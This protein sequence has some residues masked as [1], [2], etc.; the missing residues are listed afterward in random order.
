MPPQLDGLVR[1]CL[2]R[3]PQ[4]R[5]QSAAELRDLLQA[6]T[7]TGPEPSRY[8]TRWHEPLVRAPDPPPAAIEP[9]W[10]KPSASGPSRRRAAFAGFPARP[11]CGR[12]RVPAVGG[13]PGFLRA[14]A[15]GRAQQRGCRRSGPA[16]GGEAR[17]RGA[18]CPRPEPAAAGGTQTPGR[19]T[20]ARRRRPPRR[21]REAFCRILGR[22]AVRPGQAAP[23]CG[24][25]RLGQSRVWS[26]AGAP[27]RGRCGP[28]GRGAARRSRHCAPRSRPDSPPSSRAMPRQHAGS[29]TS[30][31][32]SIRRMPPRSAASAA[33]TRWTKC[34]R[35]WPRPPSTSAAGRPPLRRQPIARR[36]RSIRTPSQRAARSGASRPRRPATPFGA[37]V[38]D[39]LAALSRKDYA[40]AR[41][42]YERAGR[43]R[44][45]APE[46]REGLEQVERAIG[47]R[48]IGTHLDAA[49]KA[50]REERWGDAL[51]EYRKA[52][53]IDSNLLDAQ[54][55]V[56]RVEPRV[57]LDAELTSYL[58][59]PERVFSERHARRRARD[60]RTGGRGAE[61][62]PGA[63]AADRPSFAICW[64]PPRRRFA[65]R[66]H[67]TT[68]PT[69]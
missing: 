13:G 45:G 5:P 22:G 32:R 67:P 51:I 41:A 33:S 17:A 16:G 48:S 63:F 30:R 4:Q 23:R 20:P 68:R 37:A 57:M 55:G 47:D 49:Q 40:A 34:A 11:A 2:A 25:C 31:S 28:E 46:V 64:P 62:G 7:A 18:G 39:A 9:Q 29:L 38:A 26:R 43:I 21:S 65:S 15:M 10:R 44:P 54:Q 3:Q 6:M 60:G 42:A 14:A 53:K 1:R 56:E 19:R 50:E 66:S 24:G 12:T 59:R 8:V 27:A 36:C 58:E 61:P 52:L 69:W 35:C